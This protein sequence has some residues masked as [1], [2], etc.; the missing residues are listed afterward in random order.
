[1]N[2]RLSI[3]YSGVRGRY[4][5]PAGGAEEPRRTAVVDAAFNLVRTKGAVAFMTRAKALAWADLQLAVEAV[6][7][8]R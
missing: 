2:R 6:E 4:S 3:G 8:A 7:S 5:A 1:M